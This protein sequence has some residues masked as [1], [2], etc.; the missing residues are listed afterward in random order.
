MKDETMNSLLDIEVLHFCYW[1]FNSKQVLSIMTWSFQQPGVF[2]NPRQLG[3]KTLAWGG[4]R[5]Q[6][7]S[8]KVNTCFWCPMMDIMP[9]CLLS[10]NI[11][12]SGTW[13]L[14]LQNGLSYTKMYHSNAIFIQRLTYTVQ[15]DTLFL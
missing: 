11:H 2:K 1:I 14:L 12:Y 13:S 7:N 6:S 3:S 9:F 4:L 5:K 8:W 10:W 15:R